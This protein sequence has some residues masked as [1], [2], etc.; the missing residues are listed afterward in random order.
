[1]RCPTWLRKG[2]VAVH[3]TSAL[4]RL[5]SFC[6]SPSPPSVSLSPSHPGHP[7]SPC[8]PSPSVTIGHHLSL[9]LPLSPSPSVTQGTLC[10]PVFCYH[11]PPSV[12]PSPSV[13]VTLSHPLSLSRPVTLCP[14]TTRQ[15][16]TTYICTASPDQTSPEPLPSRPPAPSLL[17]IDGHGQRMRQPARCGRLRGCARVELLPGNAS[18]HSGGEAALVD[19]DGFEAGDVH[20]DG[21]LLDGTR[22][23]VVPRASY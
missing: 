18:A 8:L 12:A 11:R 20:H 9:C 21:A 19:S 16:A 23:E 15:T 1:M 17:Q 14:R 3:A 22:G 6:P 13:P 4:F 2:Q 7:L 5:S 10:H